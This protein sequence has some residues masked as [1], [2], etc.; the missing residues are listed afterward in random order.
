MFKR[1]TVDGALYAGLMQHGAKQLASI[2][3][4]FANTKA[5]ALMYMHMDEDD[6]KNLEDVT[7]PREEQYE[8]KHSKTV[9]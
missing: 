7:L 5:V 1:C 2:H 4:A 6:F 3:H 8:L 9:T